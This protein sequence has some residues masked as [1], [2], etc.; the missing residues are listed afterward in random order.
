MGLLDG[1]LGTPGRIYG[2]IFDAPT[3]NRG[4]AQVDPMANQLTDEAMNQARANPDELVKQQMAGTDQARNVLESADTM[5]QRSAGLGGPGLNEATA[6][7]I[8]GRQNKYFSGELA[9]IKSEAEFNKYQLQAQKQHMAAQRVGQMESIKQGVYDRQR[10]YDAAVRQ[11]RQSVINN[12]L[13][14]VGMGAGMYFGGAAGASAGKNLGQNATGT[15]N[16][17]GQ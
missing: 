9:K 16:G 4:Y 12:V 10:E 13:G 7:A 1:I 2:N 11:Q 5:Q 3:V 14:T 17:G 15:G 8:A 6:K